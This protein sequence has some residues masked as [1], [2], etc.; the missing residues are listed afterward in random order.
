MRLLQTLEIHDSSIN[1]Q[2]RP[3]WAYRD[4]IA[5][6]IIRYQSKLFN[7]VPKI[8][9]DLETK[10]KLSSYDR[11]LLNQFNSCLIDNLNKRFVID[12]VQPGLLTREELDDITKPYYESLDDF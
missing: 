10:Q 4:E 7:K 9:R 6:Q 8:F 11:F 5:S 1:F 2:L 12:Y 3:M